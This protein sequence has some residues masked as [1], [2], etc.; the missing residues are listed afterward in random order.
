VLLGAREYLGRAQGHRLIDLAQP[1]AAA[2]RIVIRI[3]VFRRAAV[4]EADLANGGKDE[5]P[6]PIAP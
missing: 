2:T 4:R 5:T 1:D 6:P 3:D